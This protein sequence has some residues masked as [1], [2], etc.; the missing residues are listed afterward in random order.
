MWYNEGIRVPFLF[1]FLYLIKI[2]SS[3]K[4]NCK[5][6][7][8]NVIYGKCMWSLGSLHGSFHIESLSLHV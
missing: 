6:L 1:P 8:R 2:T 4:K 7:V 5:T 3:S